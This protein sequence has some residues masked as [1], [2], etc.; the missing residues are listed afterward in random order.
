LVLWAAVAGAFV[1]VIRPMGSYLARVYTFEPTV[2]DRPMRP[3]EDAIFRLAGVD[4]HSTMT[5]VQ[6]GGA[7]VAINLAWLVLSYV[8]LRLQGVL[9][10]TPMHFAGLKPELAFNTAASF[11]TNTNWQAYSG[12]TTLSAFS[13]FANLSY[14]QFVTPASGAACGVAFVRALSG[15]P[16]GNF[17][18]DTTLTCTRILLPLALLMAL[19]LVWQ[20]V[21]QTLGAYLKVHTLSGGLQIVPRGPIASWEAIEHLGQNGGGYTNA[22]SAS[23]LD[24]PT[25][26]TNFV[27]MVAMALIPVSFFYMFGVMTGRR[28]VALTLIGVASAFFLLMLVMICFPEHAGNPLLNALGLAGHANMEGKEVRFG[29][30]GTSIFDDA[31]MALS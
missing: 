1:I 20:G 6:Y 9:P 27:E 21:P 10:F 5:A 3:I 4:R 31:T 2:L 13:Q 29:L 28:K 8:F 16:L 22:N 11:T 26:L 12:E 14:L 30:G 24:N 23:P 18:V 25:P 19:V 17:F 15:R 7:F